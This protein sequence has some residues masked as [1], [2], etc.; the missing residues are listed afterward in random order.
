MPDATWSLHPQLAKDTINIGDLPLSRVL[1]IKDA[2]YP[3]MLLVPRR[4]GAVEIIDLDEVAQAQL[5]TEIARVSRA[6][7]EITK[8]DKL[9]VAA[10][11]NM[12]PQLHIHVIARRT[13]DA[14]WPRP[15]W[16]AAPALPH[17]AEE[18]Q[19]F[20]GAIRRKIW[21]G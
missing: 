9:N 8:C 16:G 19:H 4:E 12:V 13:S 17:D 2:N 15:V 10:L 5:M 7:K 20:I 6:L 21:L 11:G 18:V 1:V 14:A 3:W